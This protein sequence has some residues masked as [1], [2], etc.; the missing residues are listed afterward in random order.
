MFHAVLVSW[1]NR[2]DGNGK[3]K[4]VWTGRDWVACFVNGELDQIAMNKAHVYASLAR[5]DAA[6]KRGRVKNPH[7]NLWK[8]ARYAFEHDVYYNTEKV[9]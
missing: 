8:H 9:W 7:S 1:V 2:V 3:V 5:A 6:L 4:A